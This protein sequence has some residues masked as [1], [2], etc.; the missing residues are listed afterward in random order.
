MI[1]QC[2]MKGKLMIHVWETQN[3][4]RSERRVVIADKGIN[5]AKILSIII[6]VS[7]VLIIVN[8]GDDRDSH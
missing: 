8:V 1:Q 5:R 3:G 4:K 2:K 7:S 6:I